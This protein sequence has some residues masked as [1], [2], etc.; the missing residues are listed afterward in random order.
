MNKLFTII[1]TLAFCFCL[2]GCSGNGCHEDCKC[3]KDGTCCCEDGVCK[4]HCEC[5]NCDCK[6]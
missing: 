3:Q 5:D 6:K 2:A 1:C 4:D